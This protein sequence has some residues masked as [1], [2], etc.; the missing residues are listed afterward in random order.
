MD[1]ETGSHLIKQFPQYH[2]ASKWLSLDLNLSSHAPEPGWC[3]II[4]Y[5]QH[6]KLQWPGS[7]HFSSFPTL[8]PLA[9]GIPAINPQNSYVISNLYAFTSAFYYAFVIFHPNSFL[10]L[11]TSCLSTRK[12]PWIFPL[13]PRIPSCTPLNPY[14]SS[15]HSCYLCYNF[16]SVCLSHQSGN[17]TVK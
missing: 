3:T 13:L 6:P 10:R 2:R 7:C 4:L 9:H 15:Y 16:P 11:N 12:P 1:K 14:T 5:N 8:C 17:P